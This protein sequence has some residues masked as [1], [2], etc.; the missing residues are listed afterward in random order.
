MLRNIV[1]EGKYFL[2]GEYLAAIRDFAL[3][4]GINAKKLL[5]GSM[6]PVESLLNPPARI[7]ELSMYRVG[8]NLL[9]EVDNLH[10]ASVEY[11]QCL[12]LS[13]HG[14][15][16]LAIQG[17]KNLDEAATLLVKY[18]NTRSDFF[19]IEKVTATDYVHLRIKEYQSQNYKIVDQVE[20]FFFFSTLL[21]MAII[22]KRLLKDNQAQRRFVINM[23]SP[24]VE[25][26][27]EDSLRDF[28]DINLGAP[29]SELCVPSEWMFVPF[30]PANTELTSMAAN[31]CKDELVEI[32]STNL[33]SEIREILRKDIANMPTIS[34]I[35]TRLFMSTSKLQRKLKE[36]GTTYQNLKSE[37]MLVAARGLLYQKEL[38]L[39]EIAERLGFNNPS[40]FSK[41]F[42]SYE[43]VTPKQFRS[44]VPA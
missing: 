25:I 42:K 3:R 19:E 36:R 24:N 43:G 23:D 8:N 16:G 18:I 10:G 39:D 30:S 2:A 6:I 44:S 12:A 4:K 32:N 1:G 5:E 27:L 40:N 9:S 31:C 26:V 15:L 17:A 35:A 41:S 13:A 14:A 21:N 34:Q 7:G 11:G 28:V 20:F 33:L 37:E 29:N 22:G 38:S